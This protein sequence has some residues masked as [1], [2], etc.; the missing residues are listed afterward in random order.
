MFIV[1]TVY[2][3]GM[4][5]KTSWPVSKH[6]PRICPGGFIKQMRNMIIVVLQSRLKIRYFQKE[7]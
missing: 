1:E 2:K 3:N 7:N 6:S 4:G 5:K